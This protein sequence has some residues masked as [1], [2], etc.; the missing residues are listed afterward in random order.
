MHPEVVQ[1]GMG[2]ESSR[3][4]EM[5]KYAGMYKTCVGKHG[6][7]KPWLWVGELYQNEL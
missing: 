1:D 4:G 5:I 3:H 6:R 7:T 2:E